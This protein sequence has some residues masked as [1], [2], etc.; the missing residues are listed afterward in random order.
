MYFIDAKRYPLAMD[1]GID[2]VDA[3]NTPEIFFTSHRIARTFPKLLESRLVLAYRSILPPASLRSQLSTSP[4][5]SSSSSSSSS[6]SGASHR[7]WMGQWVGRLALLMVT[8]FPVHAQ[9]LFLRLVEPLVLAGGALLIVYL[10]RRTLYL[11][12]ALGVMAALLLLLLWELFLRNNRVSLSP[13]LLD[14]EQEFFSARPRESDD[15][16]GKAAAASNDV[17]RGEEKRDVSSA[18]SVAVYGKGKGTALNLPLVSLASFPNS[19]IA[20]MPRD[21]VWSDDSL[22]SKSS[23]QFDYDSDLESSM[24]STILNIMHFI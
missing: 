10:M 16:H 5:T 1:M 11:L 18:Q 20:S 7:Q 21:S 6:S 4:T 12:I 19:R 14:E 17:A 23:S 2:L 8:Y 13:E 9:Q 22:E 24:I 3:V 15:S